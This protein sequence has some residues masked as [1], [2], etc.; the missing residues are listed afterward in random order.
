M[1]ALIMK[2][3]QVQYTQ[4]PE[5]SWWTA[6]IPDEPAV[7][8]QGKTLVEAYRH[9]RNALALVLKKN[10][11]SLVLM[12]GKTVWKRRNDLSGQALRI[13]RKEADLRIKL[14]EIQTELERATLHAVEILKI[15]KRFSYGHVGL[16]LGITRQRIEQIT[17]LPRGSQIQAKK[18][19][20]SR[21]NALSR[22][23][24]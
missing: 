7:V 13:V 20:K 14:L 2:T 24:T 3:F 17:R 15:E 16:L 18:I 19:S 4:D 9:V 12:H 23:G 8:S 1:D 22:A 6:T 5:T 21:R 10:P 11:N